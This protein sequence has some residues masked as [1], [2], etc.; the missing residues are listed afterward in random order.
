MKS[1]KKISREVFLKNLGRNTIILGSGIT[2]AFLIGKK[3]IS[4][5]DTKICKT[6]IEINNCDLPEALSFKRITKK[7]SKG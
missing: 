2:A 7:G 6:C 4:D 3:I 1:K 5:C